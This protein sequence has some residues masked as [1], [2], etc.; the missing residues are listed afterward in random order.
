MKSVPIGDVLKNPRDYDGKMINIAGTVQDV[1]TP[2]PKIDDDLINKAFEYAKSI[3]GGESA[4]SKEKRNYY[5]TL[6]N[7]GY[8]IK[9][10]TNRML[11]ITG[12]KIKVT[13][14]VRQEG[15]IAENR[16]IIVFIENNEEP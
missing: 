15:S 13:G 14:K 6:E 4:S 12:T 5:F 7:K 11:P 2:I 8:T 10:L 1:S 16:Y 3:W 9:V